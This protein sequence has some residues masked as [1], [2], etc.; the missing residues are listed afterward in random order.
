M[1]IKCLEWIVNQNEGGKDMALTANQYE[2]WGDMDK[3]IEKWKKYLKERERT[4]EKFPKYGDPQLP[5][6]RKNQ[7]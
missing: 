3:A 7:T 6:T 2:F 5:P 4:P 1:Q